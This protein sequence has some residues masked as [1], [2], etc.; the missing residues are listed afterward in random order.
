[1]LRIGITGGYGS[2]KS[3]AA[4]FFEKKGY[5][6]LY[7]D[8]LAKRLMTEDKNIRSKLSTL[9]GTNTYNPDGSLNRQYVANTIFSDH[10][11]KRALERIVH[12]AVLAY[13]DNY[14]SKLEQQQKKTFAFI[15]AALIFESGMEKMLDYVIV[16]SAPEEQRA[17]RIAKRDGVSEEEI[18]KRIAAQHSEVHLKTKADFVIENKGDIDYL[19]ERCTF[20][21]Q[22]F[23]SLETTK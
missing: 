12:P 11:K 2:G 14:F 18:R 8:P 16:V 5:P 22:L 15:E 20:L 19:Y 10:G 4:Q 23:H 3:T 13:I 6:V 17:R 9:L 7:A 1:M 21:E